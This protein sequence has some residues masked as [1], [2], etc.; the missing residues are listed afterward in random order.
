MAKIILPSDSPAEALRKQL[1]E[2]IKDPRKR[3]FEEYRAAG[4]DSETAA[5]LSDLGS[6]DSAA[7]AETILSQA[8]VSVPS[9]YDATRAVVTEVPQA[10]RNIGSATGAAI[11]SSVGML[12]LKQ[13]V[14]HSTFLFV[15]GFTVVGILGTYAATKFVTGSLGKF[16]GVVA[17]GNVA[18]A[19]GLITVAF[20]KGPRQ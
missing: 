6:M 16:L 18:A 19:A 11:G 1:K 2:A 12:I 17:G 13:A 10:L 15:G 9:S 4:F 8:V 5:S 7:Q 3:L 14:N 20:L